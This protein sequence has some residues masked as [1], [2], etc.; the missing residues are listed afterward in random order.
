MP[1]QP[2]RDLKTNF[3]LF[4]LPKLNANIWT[5]S[6]VLLKKELQ[7]LSCT[8]VRMVQGVFESPVPELNSAG[9]YQNTVT[10]VSCSTGEVPKTLAVMC[11]NEVMPG[12]LACSKCCS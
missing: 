9:N 6:S 7:K 12:W 10:R 2:L 1:F 11:S 3:R 8:M 4:F 5:T